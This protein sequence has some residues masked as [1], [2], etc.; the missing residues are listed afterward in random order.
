MSRLKSS[1]YFTAMAASSST[2]SDMLVELCVTELEDVSQNP[3]SA[4]LKPLPVVQESCHPY[5]RDARTSGHVKIHGSE[6][7]LVEFDRQCS[8]EPSGDSVTITDGT[9]RVVAV[10]SGRDPEVWADVVIKG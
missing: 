1:L 6:S 9:G 2:V 4:P 5:G 10:R 8:T 3:L 7:L